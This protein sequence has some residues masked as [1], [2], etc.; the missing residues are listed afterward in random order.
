LLWIVLG[1][2]LGPAAALGF[3]RFAYALLL[4][5]MRADLG[6][7]YAEAGAMNGANA[8]GYLGGALIAA[9][10]AQKLGTK[11]TFMLGLAATAAALLLSA[12]VRS[13]PALLALR[14]AA[15]ATGAMVFVAGGG[16]AAMAGLADTRRAALLLAVYFAGPGIGILLS[17][18]V[19]WF[20]TR[21]ATAD[22]PGGWLALG[23]A[24]LL[25]ALAA[26]PA[27]ARAPS[28]D[29]PELADLR[30]KWRPL[31]SLF[32]AYALFGSGYIAYM[33]FIV[34]FLRNG[35]FTETRITVFWTILGAAAVVA[36]FAWGPILARLPAGRGIFVVLLVLLLGAVLP[37]VISGAVAAFLSAALFGSSFLAVVT[38]ITH[39]ARQVTPP[40]SWTRVIGA[41]TVAFA[42][43]QCLGPVLAGV[44]SDSANGL[45]AGM[46]L[47][48][49]L[50]ATAALV[51]LRQPPS[52]H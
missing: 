8:L 7:T 12:A 37:L 45:R 48:V 32:I 14:L 22:W 11:K 36:A 13:F 47:S 33:T 2:A 17:G 31:S 38:A 49:V 18:P 43:G 50:L 4:P 16:L 30:V 51:A 1:L 46:L 39:A 26:L 5:S 42:L 19:V 35:G 24:T 20:G 15:G 25:A 21:G 40:G 44:L 10:V 9:A 28:R 3:A 41:L 6:W 27:L 52:P 34:A 29:G 23:A